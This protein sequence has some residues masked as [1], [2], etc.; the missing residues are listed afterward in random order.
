M[1]TTYKQLLQIPKS[2]VQ[3]KRNHVFYGS[4]KL[5]LF[6]RKGQ[7]LKWRF[8]RGWSIFIYCAFYWLCW[9]WG[10]QY[11]YKFI[12]FCKVWVSCQL[13]GSKP[14]WNGDSTRCLWKSNRWYAQIPNRGSKCINYCSHWRTCFPT[15]FLYGLLCLLLWNASLL[16]ENWVWNWWEQ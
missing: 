13:I 12:G 8:N 16:K 9:F 7:S 4:Y 6:I 10:W 15:R 2:W 11:C 3:L 5:R 1:A 14:S